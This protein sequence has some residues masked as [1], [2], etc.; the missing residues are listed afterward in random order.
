MIIYRHTNTEDTPHIMD[1]DKRDSGACD[2]NNSNHNDS[3]FLKNASINTPLAAEVFVLKSGTGDNGYACD[4][5]IT[6][7]SEGERLVTMATQTPEVEIQEP[8]C[9]LEES[10]QNNGLLIPPTPP[11]SSMYHGTWP[12]TKDFP[13]SQS[14]GSLESLVNNDTSSIFS[15]DSSNTNASAP[16]V[17][18]CQT[19]QPQLGTKVEMVYSLLSMLGTHDK[20]D[21][22]RTLLAMSSSQDSCIAMRQSGC[23]PLLI[24]LLHGSDKDSSLLGNTRG[25]KAARARASAALHNIVHSHPDDKRGRREARVLRLLEQIRAHC[26]QLR[27]SSSDDDEEDKKVKSGSRPS[28]I[29]HHPGP[30]IAA[31]MKLSFDEE[32]RHAICTLGGLQA[33]GELLQVDHEIHGNTTE[34][35]NITMRRYACMALTNLTFGDGTNKAL[36]CSMRGVMDALIAQLHSSNEDLCQVAASVLRNLS[37]RADLASKKTLR[38]VG[39]VTTLMKAAM[40]VKKESTLKSILSALWNLSAHCSEN[41]ADLCAVEGAVE[42]LVS[43]LTY[44]S[45]SKTLAIIENGGGVLRNVSS[46]IAVREDYR[47]LLRQHG[48]LQILL[49]HLRSPSLTIVSNACGTLWNLSARCPEDQRALWDMGAVSMLRNLVHSKHRMISMGSA[50]ALK[51]LLGAKPASLNF[52]SD[53]H[54][55]SNMPTLHARKQRAIEAEIDQNLSETCENM[56]SP[57]NSP[58][59]NRKQDT[60]SP[61]YLYSSGYQ[62]SDLDSRRAFMKTHMFMRTGSGDGAMLFDSRTRSPHRVTRSGSQDS[63]GSVHSDISHDRARVH[64]MLAK[65]SKLLYERQGSV[66]EKRRDS[67]LTRLTQEGSAGSLEKLRNAPQHMMENEDGVCDETV[68]YSN[69]YVDHATQNCLD[70]AKQSCL[71]PSKQ[72]NCPV[73]LANFAGNPSSYSAQQR[74]YMYVVP[75]Q[76]SHK[77]YTDRQIYNDRMTN[78]SSNKN[79]SEPLISSYGVYAETDLDNIDQLDQPTDYG[80]RYAEYTDDQCTDRPINYVSR[81]NDSDPNCADCR[82]EEARRTNER[83]E[84]RVH[85]VHDDSLKTFCTEGTPLNYLS[86]ATSLTDL[87][88]KHEKGEM[89]EE[90]KKDILESCAEDEIKNY[91]LDYQN[92]E[93]TGNNNNNNNNITNNNKKIKRGSNT[94]VSGIPTFRSSIQC[95]K[96][97]VSSKAPTE[98]PIDVDILEDPCEGAADQM[99]TY[100]DEGTPI[101]YSQVSPISS[102]H[103]SEAGDHENLPRTNVLKSIDENECSE[104]L[105]KTTIS[106]KT[107]SDI[108]NIERKL[109]SVDDAEKPSESIGTLPDAGSPSDREQKT[110]TFDE[111]HMVEETPLM[112]SRCSSLGSLSSF[113][114]HSVHSS[115]VSE[116]SRRASEVVSPSELPDSPS[117]TFPPSPTRKRAAEKCSSVNDQEPEAMEEMKEFT[118]EA[119]ERDPTNATGAKPTS[120]TLADVLKGELISD[121]GKL[122]SPTVYNTEGTPPNFSETTSLSALTFSDDEPQMIGK[123]THIKTAIKD[124]KSEKISEKDDKEN[125]SMSEVSEGEEDI[126]AQCIS[127][128]MPSNSSKKIRRST[129]DNALKKKSESWKTES[130]TNNKSKLPTK[131]VSNNARTN[132]GSLK[133]KSCLRSV[134]VCKQ[135]EDLLNTDAVKSYATEGTPLNFSRTTSLSD[136]SIL[137]HDNASLKPTGC[138]HEEAEESDN[139]SVCDEND[140]LLSEVI[141]SAKPKGKVG[142]KPTVIDRTAEGS[143]SKE[144]F[145]FQ[146][147]PLKEKKCISMNPDTVKTYA[148][149]GTPI[150][151]SNATSLSDLTIDSIDGLDMGFVQKNS[152]SKPGDPNYTI[153]NKD[154]S[155]FAL[156]SAADSPKHYMMEG[157]PITFSR[158]DSLSSLSCDDTEDV[159]LSHHPSAKQGKNKSSPSLGQ[160]WK[161]DTGRKDYQQSPDGTGVPGTELGR[162]VVGQSSEEIRPALMDP[163]G[164]LSDEIPKEFAIEDTP[165]TY[166][167]N[168]ST[169]SYKNKCQRES[170]L[171]KVSSTKQTGPELGLPDQK[172]SFKVEGTPLCFS[173]NSSLSSLSIES[174]TNDF[175]LTEE[176]LLEECINSA[177]PRG[178]KSKSDKI[179]SKSSRLP[180]LNSPGTIPQSDQV[181]KDKTSLCVS[182]SESLMS[183]SS[184]DYSMKHV[185]TSMV[186]NISNGQGRLDVNSSNE[187]TNANNVQNESLRKSTKSCSDFSTNPAVDARQRFG[188]CRSKSQDSDGFLKRK[189]D[190]S[191]HEIAQANSLSN[192]PFLGLGETTEQNDS[193]P[194][195]NR[196]LEEKQRSMQEI[197]MV[198]SLPQSIGADSNGSI[199]KVDSEKS[200]AADDSHCE[201]KPS[202]SHSD[203]IMM[204]SSPDDM[205]SDETNVSDELEHED[206]LDINL[207]EEQGNNVTDEDKDRNSFEHEISPEEERALEE[208]A[209]LVVCELITKR[210]LSSSTFDEDSLIENESISLVSNDYTSD[211]AS[212][213]S[214]TWSKN[215]EDLSEYSTSTL[216][217]SE[218]S[219][220][221]ARIVKPSGHS[222]PI[223]DKSDQESNKSV[224][225]RRKPLYSRKNPVTTTP[226]KTLNSKPDNS[227]V[228][229][230][231]STRQPGGPVKSNPNSPKKTVTKNTNATSSEVPV[232]KV[233]PRT[234][235]VRRSSGGGGRSMSPGSPLK[236]QTTKQSAG[237]KLPVVNS[238][239]PA[240]DSSV[241]RGGHSTQIERPKPPIKQG[242]FTKETPASSGDKQS[243]SESDKNEN[244]SDV[245]TSTVKLRER[246]T[247]SS[248]RSSG[249]STGSQR[250]SDTTPPESWTKALGSFNFL[251]DTS[252]EQGFH[253]PF[254]QIQRQRNSR[255]APPALRQSSTSTTPTKN[256]PTKVTSPVGKGGSRS[257]ATSNKSGIGSLKKNTP[258]SSSPKSNGSNLDKS[259]S[260]S[261]GTLRKTS[262]KT[263]LKNSDSNASLKKADSNASLKKTDSNASLK[264]ASDNSRPSTPTGKRGS[265]GLSK[266]QSISPGNAQSK[267]SETSPPSKG[268]PTVNENRRSSSTGKKPV[269]SK[270]A[271]LWK[272]NE[273]S[274]DSAS[275]PE[276]KP[277][278]PPRQQR[279]HSTGGGQRSRLV[280]PRISNNKKSSSP[281][282]TQGLSRTHTYDK[283]SSFA[284]NS[285]VVTEKLNENNSSVVKSISPISS[286]K[287]NKNIDSFNED[288]T[289]TMTKT[290]SGTWKTQKSR[291][292][293]QSLPDADQTCRVQEKMSDSKKSL[294]SMTSDESWKNNN[295]LSEQQE[296][297]G[298]NEDV[299]VKRNE[300]IKEAENKMLLDNNCSEVKETEDRKGSAPRQGNC[301]TKMPLQ[302]KT[303]S[304]ETVIDSLPSEAK[305]WKSELISPQSELKRAICSEVRTNP[306]C[307]ISAAIVS[308]F[309]YTPSA[310]S[311]NNNFDQNR[312]LAKAVT[313]GNKRSSI[314]SPSKHATK[315]E[316][317]LARRRQNFMTKMEDAGDEDETRRACRVTTV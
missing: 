125:S 6:S 233:N 31:L 69:K 13:I 304:K 302:N 114:A 263:S 105:Q 100:C 113:E 142:R 292:E 25:S 185:K 269:A 52:D 88:G 56:E 207:A 270:I 305:V 243:A 109:L 166:S 172:A 267:K 95:V 291:S 246:K 276:S 153:P 17:S 83:V 176:A 186:P 285:S 99:K 309:N 159:S 81:Y 117:E 93:K 85:T 295:S 313:N 241:N 78:P 300:M 156:N 238:E 171:A 39:G 184:E 24:Q 32:H 82:L 30:A 252:H 132:Y 26:D 66:L 138:K 298:N 128:A 208:N 251:V 278:K 133:L 203:S 190:Y 119:P 87:T 112:F 218:A 210:E 236:S 175:S 36:L 12:I 226:V 195:D 28:D 50:A 68:N 158:N 168:S 86:T 225:G 242:T 64:H 191:N 35:Y 196:L 47:R 62:L 106:E 227:R 272:R 118:V 234:T 84:Q 127:S 231:A 173:R 287:E 94:H 311:Q 79:S 204:S 155:I 296:F 303:A 281:P 1:Q 177:M 199:E 197:E 2:L 209:S 259:N 123:K 53:K 147:S 161:A 37:W 154:D 211:T 284:D 139:S 222:Q 183:R 18:R 145:P 206:I 165:D 160:R 180:T 111:N 192:R 306:A 283:L 102:L 19:T 288:I 103:S 11:L 75:N 164:Y 307:S 44:K 310:K 215:S 129:S 279:S 256:T 8:Q 89:R 249:G 301:A 299:W 55:K 217:H 60:D 5:S 7:N 253:A 61:H 124:G 116:Y 163:E 59:E 261:T 167:R 262:S 97:Y 141:Q 72:N 54:V 202:K 143:E 51:N 205:N 277:T 41:K 174:V 314:P 15:F 228:I 219:S 286:P 294:N 29:D 136:L 21:M 169:N 308:P 221:R 34:Q 96:E 122:D 121:I 268:T 198:S 10:C 104:E 260:G 150:N 157:T 4:T 49:K 245:D 126:L 67:S 20:D 317:L 77:T 258:S 230:P 266:N 312:I 42:F 179:G 63:V 212:E 46:H 213:V 297:D 220:R 58:T 45:S 265:L 257:N 22:S 193:V 9:L 280:P 140:K 282:V 178:D 254:E 74:M 115:V 255:D 134:S 274:N 293:A 137:T 3:I 250:N 223:S 224:R 98:N 188:W 273:S 201:L 16:P 248:P 151:F 76:Y 14:D 149:E 182:R 214:V 48:C 146:I 135:E 316:M 107:G 43:T 92:M 33:I 130:A 108:V 189:K 229:R 101:S 194:K 271:S 27:D 162:H 315:T 235:N 181:E 110:V 23:L 131:S 232:N 187:I 290:N 239:R 237:S 289:F 244:K 91:T 152:K 73:K 80:K 40:R 57:R 148:V 71:D 216:S 200:D 275:S 70:P 247:S 170:P 90:L 240:R 120:G 144:K 38:E 264:K 65:S